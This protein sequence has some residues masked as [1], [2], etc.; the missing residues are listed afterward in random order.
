MEN[1]KSVKKLARTGTFRATT[2]A[3]LPT[4]HLSLR[5]FLSLSLSLCVYVPTRLGNGLLVL[6]LYGRYV[7]LGSRHPSPRHHRER[8]TLSG[9]KASPI[10]VPCV[11]VTTRGGYVWH[12][13]FANC[14]GSL[15]RSRR[16]LWRGIAAPKLLRRG[17]RPVRHH[18]RTAAVTVVFVIPVVLLSVFFFHPLLRPSLSL[19]SSLSFHPSAPSALLPCPRPPRC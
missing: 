10:L 15:L 17:V 2:A 14:C 19:S 7:S 1:R 12:V 18:L 3:P 6:W 4:S 8:Q 5:R 16:P 11:W 9:G 13:S